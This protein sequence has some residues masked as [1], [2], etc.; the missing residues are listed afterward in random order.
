MACTG[1]VYLFILELV[2]TREVLGDQ[3]ETRAQEP[4]AGRITKNKAMPVGKKMPAG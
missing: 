3:W 4:I 1:S 2:E